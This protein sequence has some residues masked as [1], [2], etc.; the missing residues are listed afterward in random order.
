[1]ALVIALEL[2]AKHNETQLAAKQNETLIAQI[3][4]L[5]KA[6]VPHLC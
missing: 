5:E 2:A 6:L 1:L 4:A 3:K